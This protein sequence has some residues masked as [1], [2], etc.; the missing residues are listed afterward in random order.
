MVDKINAAVKKTM[1]LPEVRARIEGT[2]SLVV[3]NTPAE[4]AAQTAAEFE[5]Y[6]KVVAVQKLKLD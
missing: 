3:A 5:V 1:D 4:F 6:K 2:G